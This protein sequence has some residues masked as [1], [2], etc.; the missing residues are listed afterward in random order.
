MIIWKA[1]SGGSRFIAPPQFEVFLLKL[2][3]AGIVRQLNKTLA[4]VPDR[5]RLRTSKLLRTRLPFV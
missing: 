2:Q 3:H 4:W 5:R 1:P